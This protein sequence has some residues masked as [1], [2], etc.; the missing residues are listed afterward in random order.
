[1]LPPLPS[2]LREY[3]EGDAAIVSSVQPVLQLFVIVELYQ[4]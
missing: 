3:R 2:G 4:A 1:M